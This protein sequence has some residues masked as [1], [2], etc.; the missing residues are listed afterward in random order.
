MF[1]VK[2]LC[3]FFFTKKDSS[4]NLNLQKQPLAD[5]DNKD[6]LKNVA[7]YTGKHATQSLFFN[8]V[9]GFQPAVLLCQKRDPGTDVFVRILRN[10]E[11]QLFYRTS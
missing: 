5:L 2:Q 10:F 9:A 6:L 1:I 3:L 11:E 7:K 8:K 4:K